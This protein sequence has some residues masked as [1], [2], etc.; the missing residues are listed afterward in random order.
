MTYGHEVWAAA[1]K[2]H[3]NK[4][5]TIQNKFFKI[6]FGKSYDS[7]IQ[8]LYRLTYMPTINDFILQ[9]INH[10]Y[11]RCHENPLIKDLDNYDTKEIPTK[12]K[13]NLPK[14]GIQL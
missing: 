8:E 10:S 1:A 11:D 12:I 6:I 7:P 4:I 5:R 13:L 9:T 2:S 14:H 3:I